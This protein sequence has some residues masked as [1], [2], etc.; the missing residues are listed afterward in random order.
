VSLVQLESFIAV[1]ET[2]HIGRAAERLR[3]TQPPRTR[4]IKSLEDELGVELFERT[5]RGMRLKP[6]GEK[7]LA[8]ARDILERVEVARRV[9]EE[10]VSSTER[11][12]APASLLSSFVP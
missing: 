8:H 4:R 10:S 9:I 11:A 12:R 5:A 1:A 7:L 3:I 6:A 2:R